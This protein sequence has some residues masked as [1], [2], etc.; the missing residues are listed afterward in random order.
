MHFNLDVPFTI[1]KRMNN[2]CVH[3]N[4]N[5]IDSFCQQRFIGPSELKFD[6]FA[7]YQNISPLCKYEDKL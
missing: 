2:C 3:V 7:I 6:Y 1:V 4:N 5:T